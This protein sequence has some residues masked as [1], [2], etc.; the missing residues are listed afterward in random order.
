MH[1]NRS[2]GQLRP[3]LQLLCGRIHEDRGFGTQAPRF[4]LG[5]SRAAVASLVEEHRSR[6]GFQKAPTG[7]VLVQPRVPL[8][9]IG[10]QIGDAPRSLIAAG[11]ADRPFDER[12]VGPV[13]FV[14]KHGQEEKFAALNRDL[15]FEGNRAP[16]CNLG[17]RE[18]AF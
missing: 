9:Q 1:K 16:F 15:V 6:C 11:F 14:R 2:S 4:H 17:L 13:I 3:D 5:P 18:N 10:H 8:Q 12:A 7:P